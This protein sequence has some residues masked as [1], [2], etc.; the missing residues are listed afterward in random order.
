MDFLAEGQATGLPHRFLK[1][2]EVGPFDCLSEG[3]TIT[4]ITFASPMLPS[5][6][7]WAPSRFLFDSPVRTLLDLIALSDYIQRNSKE[8]LWPC[9][10]LYCD[11]SVGSEHL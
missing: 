3:T 11:L 5:P 1:G 10:F 7:S 9:F 4:L 6:A 8:V 2:P